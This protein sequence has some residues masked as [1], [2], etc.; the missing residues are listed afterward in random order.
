MLELISDNDLSA[1][2]GRRIEEFI[3]LGFNAKSVTHEGFVPFVIPNLKARDYSNHFTIVEAGL[4]DILTRWLDPNVDYG[5]DQ[6]LELMLYHIGNCIRILRAKSALEQ[7]MGAQQGSIAWMDNL[8][9]PFF[10]S[11]VT[12]IEVNWY[13]IVAH[14]VYCLMYVDHLLFELDMVTQRHG[15]G[16]L[17]D[18]G[19]GID[20]EYLA[21]L[22]KNPLANIPASIK[23]SK[24]LELMPL[25]FAIDTLHDIEKDC[26][27]SCSDSNQDM[28]Y[29]KSMGTSG[30]NK[31]TSSDYV[32]T[33]YSIM[34]GDF[35]SNERSVIPHFKGLEARDNIINMFALLLK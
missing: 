16:V 19:Y 11:Y 1:A 35:K 22:L 9:V 2:T 26:D 20:T 5:L 25:K 13:I 15:E 30:D 23:K 32:E 3:D 28:D 12:N 34:N 31:G 8:V 27:T 6:Y 10:E 18:I 17:R 21:V 24:A 4:Q 29:I 7:K 33:L 14:I